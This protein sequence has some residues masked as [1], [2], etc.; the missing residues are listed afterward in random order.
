MIHGPYNVKLITVQQAKII[1]IYVWK[2][3][4]KLYKCIAAIWY[5]KTCKPHWVS[6]WTA[7][8][9]HCV[10]YKYLRTSHI[11]KRLALLVLPYCEDKGTKIFLNV[12]NYQPTL[13]NI[14]K[15]LNF[16]GYRCVNLK[17]RTILSC[18]S[19]NNALNEIRI[20]TL[21]PWLHS[22]YNVYVLLQ[23]HITL[24]TAEDNELP[25]TFMNTHYSNAVLI[26]QI[27]WQLSAVGSLN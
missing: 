16:H 27:I 18:S 3:Q 12:C 19:V 25:R 14:P 22:T 1:R 11:P 13:P 8:I 10:F 15:D 5:N 20:D 23:D 9:S 4:V 7:Y 6:C 21:R 17:S 2:H 26:R 24:R